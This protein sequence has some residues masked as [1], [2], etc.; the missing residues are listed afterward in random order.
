MSQKIIKLTESQLRGIV[1]KVILKETL[2]TEEGKYF[3]SQSAL[4]IWRSYYHTFYTDLKAMLLGFQHIQSLSD[5]NTGNTEISKAQGGKYPNGYVDV[6]NDNVMAGNLDI[7]NGI[8]AAL[9]KIGVNLQF[10]TYNGGKSLEQYS[11]SIG[12]PTAPKSSTSTDNKATTLPTVTVS[13]S[14]NKVAPKIN[15]VKQSGKFPLKYL[16]VGGNIGTLQ[17]ALGMRGDTYFGNQTEKA[18]LAKAPEYKRETGVTR[19]IYNKIVPNIA[20]SGDLKKTYDMNTQTGKD[21]YLQQALKPAPQSFKNIQNAPQLTS[22]Q[23]ADIDR[24][25]ARPAYGT[26]TPPPPEESPSVQNPY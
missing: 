6:L 20:V 15:W 4:E 17:K 21:A 22:Q 5:F 1:S 26:P 23:Q 14:K 19:E 11:F 10:R 18:V 16:E 3:T 25:A 24:I 9:A 7:A 8:K 12:T 13:S 2:L